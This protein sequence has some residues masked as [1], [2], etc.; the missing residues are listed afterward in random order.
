MRTRAQVVAGN[1]NWN[2]SIEGG[3]EDYVVIRNWPIASGANFTPRDVLVA[4]KVCLLGATVARTLFPDQDPVGQ[5]MRVK[6]LP[7]RV[8]GVLAPKGQGQ[9]GDDQDD[10]ILAPYTT[11]QKKLLGITHLNRVTVSAAQRRRRWRRPRSTS[12]GCCASA[13]AS[14]DP[15]DDDFTVRT[16]EEMAATRVEMANTMT[17]LLMSVASRQPAGGRHRHHEHHAGVGHGADARDRPA[18]GGGRAH[19]RHPAPV[20]GGGG[21]RCRWRAAP[22]A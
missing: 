13:T 22:S 9:F 14:T 6:N 10:F 11:V 7:F 16:V 19:A 1:Q 12:R 21:R 18:H 2:T 4:D 8:V 5:M 15:E 20:P 3:N 17:A